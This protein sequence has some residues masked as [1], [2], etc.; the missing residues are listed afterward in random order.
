MLTINF[1]FPEESLVYLSQSLLNTQGPTSG[2][3]LVP[4]TKDNKSI[5][6]FFF[7]KPYNSELFSSMW[8]LLK[9]M[10]N[11][12]ETMIEFITDSKQKFSQV[13]SNRDHHRYASPYKGLFCLVYY[14]KPAYK[15]ENV[16]LKPYNRLKESKFKEKQKQ[17]PKGFRSMIA[18]SF[19]K[20]INQIN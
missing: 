20:S 7:V 11:G 17:E 16:T 1:F 15:P 4:N 18:R 8:D 9:I 12:K 10:D 13:S 5:V 2:W 19:I 6:E 3:A 14:C